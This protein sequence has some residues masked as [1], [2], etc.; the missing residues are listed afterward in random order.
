MKKNYNLINEIDGK[1]EQI[2]YNYYNDYL[3]AGL[4]KD[5]RTELIK[6]LKL[7]VFKNNTTYKNNFK[8]FEYYFYKYA[9]KTIIEDQISL[10][11]TGLHQKRLIQFYT[12]FLGLNLI[13][14][15]GM[16]KHITKYVYHNSPEAVLRLY[17]QLFW[18]FN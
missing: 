4:N 18:R 6:A 9:V 10:K 17:N 3:I 8:C 14:P 2:A 11:Y 12:D 13:G 16:Y 5:K 7:L 1:I 15:A